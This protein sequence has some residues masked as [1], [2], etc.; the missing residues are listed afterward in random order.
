MHQRTQGCR[1]SQALLPFICFRRLQRLLLTAAAVATLVKQQ[2]GI[3][4]AFVVVDVVIGGGGGVLHGIIVVDS[5][6]NYFGWL[7]VFLFVGLSL[8]VSQC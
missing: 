6:R 7:L 5:H 3:L 8:H 2:K 4:D 1:S